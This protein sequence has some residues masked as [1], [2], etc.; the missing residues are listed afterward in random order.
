[1]TDNKKIKEF[2]DFFAECF[3]YCSETYKDEYFPYVKKFHD[4]LFI[5]LN[6]NAKYSRLKNPF[7]SNGE[8][9]LKDYEWLAD[10]MKKYYIDLSK[11][12]V[13]VHHHFNKIKINGDKSVS[14][15]WQNVEKQTMKL[16]KKKRLFQS[17][18]INKIDLVMHGHL[19]E[20]IEYFRKGIRF[21]NAGG[22]IL[23][24]EEELKINLF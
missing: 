3:Q 4:V 10:V 9:T 6:S 5:G 8:I 24:N 20:S 16:R 7:A 1:M 11:K 15:F 2:G 23:G 17:F 19:H 22:S 18:K 21:L 12:L 14:N 13:L